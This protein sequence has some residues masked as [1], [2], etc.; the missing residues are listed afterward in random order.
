MRRRSQFWEVYCTLIW[1]K[2]P[3]RAESLKGRL[4]DWQTYQSVS[5]RS[6]ESTCL[7]HHNLI[8]FGTSVL[9]QGKVNMPLNICGYIKGLINVGNAITV[10]SF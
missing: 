10:L 1:Y 9:C 4:M 6:V 3:S 8:V 2:V 7:R 5:V